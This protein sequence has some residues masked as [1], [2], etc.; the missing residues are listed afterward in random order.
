M[1]S[2][3]LIEPRSLGEACVALAAVEDVKVIAGGTALLPMIKQRLML[4]RLLVNLKKLRDA[5]EIS[6]DSQGGVRIG[7]LATINEI[8][9]SPLLR[10]LYPVLAEACHVVANIRIRNMATLG[11]NL[12]H[13]DYQS[14]PPTVLS[15]LDA[16]VELRSQRGTRTLSLGDFQLGSYETALAPGELVSAVLIPPPPDGLKGLYMKFTS[17]SSEERPCAGIAAFI[18]TENGIC[19][20]LRLAVGAVSAQPVRINSAEERARNQPLTTELM[21]AIADESAR[22]VRPIDDIRGPADYKRHLV[23]VLAGRAL[24]ALAVGESEIHT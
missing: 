18:R 6:F 2:F 24:T 21:Q 16:R 15:A 13:G 12:A 11:G 9:T 1:R 14:D 17:G 4:P 19:R 8:E 7:A 5:S 22:V 20:E 3:E 23:G 10:K